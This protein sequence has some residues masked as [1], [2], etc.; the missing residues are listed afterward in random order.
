[1]KKLMKKAMAIFLALAIVFSGG[2]VAFADEGNAAVSPYISIREFF[3]GQGGEVEWDREN[4]LILASLEDFEFVLRPGSAEVLRNGEAITITY[5]IT[6]RENIAFIHTND[7]LLLF[8]VEVELADHLPET[9]AA[10][11]AVIPDIM[12]QFA[13]QGLTM[14]MVDAQEGFT[15]TQGFGLANSHA[16]TPVDENTIF[17]LASIS[18]PFTAIAVMQLVEAGLIDLDE[19]IVTYLPDFS[20]IGGYRNITVRMLLSH[21]SGIPLDFTGSGMFTT[22]NYYPGLMDNF[23]ELLSTQAMIAPAGTQHQYANNAFTLLGVLI[24]T[25]AT[26]YDSAFEG[27]VSYMN[28]N[29]FAPAGMSRSTFALDDSHWAYKSRAYAHTG[30]QEDFIFFNALPTGGLMSTA[31][32]MAQFMH[33]VLG[34]GAPLLSAASFEQ[35][36]TRQDFGM[37]HNIDFM[38]PASHPGLGFVHYTNMSGFEFAGHNGTLVHFHSDMVFCLDTGIG[39]FVSVNSTTGLPMAREIAVSFLISAIVEKTGDVNIPESD[40]T[41]V[42][43]ELGFETLEAMEGWFIQIGPS[44]GLVQV[45]A[46]EEGYLTL[47][48]AIPGL[49]LMLTPLSDGSFVCTQLGLRVRFDEV[50]GETIILLGE[51]GAVLIAI[52]IDPELIIAPEGFEKWTGTYLAYTPPGHVSVLYRIEVGIDENG[53]AYSRVFTLHHLNMF[54][55]IISI[56]GELTTQFEEDEYG[57]WLVL[58]DVRFLRVD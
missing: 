32:D 6:I 10:A 25:I 21:A 41:V 3:V 29:V 33:I 47:H 18:K 44:D 42:P 53:F 17:S 40:P 30:A 2:I 28:E 26:D 4:R 11:T 16:G 58:S 49:D 38:R 13:I 37:A 8:G 51:F 36:F 34:D 12:E 56:D 52:E 48:G 23:L 14:A 9:I 22:Q 50:E 43:V 31:S 55:P 20:L 46:S 19:P 24:A 39:V 5:P 27:F 15:W 7:L 45:V 54:S 35:M 57:T 1:M